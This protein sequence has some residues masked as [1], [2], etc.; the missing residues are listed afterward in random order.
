MG[1]AAWIWIGTWRFH[2]VCNYSKLERNGK[3]MEPGTLSSIFTV[4]R[5]QEK[6]TELI[7][8]LCCKNKIFYQYHPPAPTREVILED[9]AALPPGKDYKDKYYIG[10]FENGV[11]AAIMDLILGYPE[12]DIAY[13]GLFMVDVGYQKKSIGSKIITECAGCLRMS[14]FRSIRLAV[15]RGNPQSNAFWKK[16]GFLVTGQTK[17][18]LME[19]SL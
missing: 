16:N 15:D 17:Y 11:L 1:Q 14:G 13:V 7:Y 10:F 19:L 18:I 4:R 2:A 9:M 3:Y 12:K 5:L 6:D 8:K